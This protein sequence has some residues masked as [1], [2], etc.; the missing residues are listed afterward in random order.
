[1]VYNC[2]L[3]VQNNIRNHTVFNVKLPKLIFGLNLTPADIVFS[4]WILHPYDFYNEYQSDIIEQ[5]D[6]SRMAAKTAADTL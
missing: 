2:A 4:Y 6:I 3:T 5:C 1:M